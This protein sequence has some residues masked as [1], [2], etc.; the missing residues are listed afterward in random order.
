[1]PIYSEDDEGFWDIGPESRVHNQENAKRLGLSLNV[2]PLG[3][4]DD[5]A[6]PL[7]SLLYIPPHQVLPRHNHP[8]HRVEVMI[9]GTLNIGGRVLHTGDVS[10]SAPGEYY[11]PHTAGEEGSLSVEIFSRADGMDSLE[12]VARDAVARFT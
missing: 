9:R 1:M 3:E 7:A 10:V 2:F 11:G 8:C 12:N 6:T 5:P 4:P